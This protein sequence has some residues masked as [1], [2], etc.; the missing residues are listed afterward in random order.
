MMW[1]KKYSVLAFCRWN[2]DRRDLNSTFR[3][4]YELDPRTRLLGSQAYWGAAHDLLQIGLALLLNVVFYALVLIFIVKI[5]RRW[6][7][8]T[9]RAHFKMGHCFCVHS[10][11]ARRPETLCI[12]T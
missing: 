8:K 12:G 3:A 1:L 10:M 9:D 11:K 7:L 2:T 6:Q 4:S 5:R